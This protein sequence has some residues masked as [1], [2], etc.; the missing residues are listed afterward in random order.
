MRAVEIR[1]WGGPEVLELRDL[2][3]PEPGANEVLIEVTRA[4]LNYADTHQRTNSYV[5]KAEL[6]L[7]PGAEVAG[8]RTDTGERVVALTGHGGYAE[9]ATAPAAA[10]TTTLSPRATLAAV[11]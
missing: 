9:Y 3:V 7:I 6:P 2:P 5:A 10:W 8:V 1:E 4:G 11:A